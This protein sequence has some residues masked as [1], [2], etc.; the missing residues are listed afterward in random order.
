ML[1]DIFVFYPIDYLQ[2][3]SEELSWKILDLIRKQREANAIL[4]VMDET[5]FSLLDAILVVLSVQSDQEHRFPPPCLVETQIL[6]ALNQLDQAAKRISA[7]TGLDFKS[8][9]EFAVRVQANFP[10]RITSALADEA[11]Q[12]EAIGKRMDAAD[13]IKKYNPSLGLGV[14]IGFVMDMGMYYKNAISTIMPAPYKYRIRK[15]G[16]RYSETLIK[17]Y[18]S[19]EIENLIAATFI[20]GS[21][22]AVSFVIWLYGHEIHEMEC[23]RVQISIIKQSHGD[24]RLLVHLLA[25]AKVDYRDVLCR[26]EMIEVKKSN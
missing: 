6:A 26:E 21:R 4:T 7:Y 23:E 8:S 15:P 3:I 18:L 13:M 1:K 25:M 14:I 17:R 20:E 19:P 2:R 12:L 24:E 11:L 9:R 22:D 16:E 10:I 5:G